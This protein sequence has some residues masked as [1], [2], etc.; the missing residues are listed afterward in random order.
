M[1]AC[2][3]LQVNRGQDRRRFRWAGIGD[4]DGGF[5]KGSR[6]DSVRPCRSSVSYSIGTFSGAKIVC[7]LREIL[8]GPDL[9]SGSLPTVF[10]IQ[11]L[12]SE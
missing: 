4:G 6:Q 10:K 5:A 2:L 3:R 1:T 7:V 8:C 11:K 9:F 12:F